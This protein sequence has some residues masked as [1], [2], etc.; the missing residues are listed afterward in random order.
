MARFG[1]HQYR[2]KRS[3]RSYLLM[4]CASL[5]LHW[6]VVVKVAATLSSARHSVAY[7][8]AQQQL[9][10][11]DG[12]YCTAVEILVLLE[13]ARCVSEAWVVTCCEAVN[14]RRSLS[15]LDLS[16][17]AHLSK[18]K[19]SI[20][21]SGRSRCVPS[22]PSLRRLTLPGVVERAGLTTFSDPS[23]SSL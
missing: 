13:K 17:V 6:L 4:A 22:D 3:Y 8:M 2:K 7:P 5:N 14:W 18:L 16:L 20:P 21:A 23:S 9:S 1:C 15:F 19:W 11:I 12:W 10:R